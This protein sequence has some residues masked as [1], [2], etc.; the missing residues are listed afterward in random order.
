[1]PRKAA[2]KS[3]R[4]KKPA[5]REIISV[6]FWALA[7]SFVLRATVVQAYHV[8]SGSMEP[9]M[10][11]GDQFLVNRAQ[12]GLKV[13]FTGQTIIPLGKPHR[14]DVV[15]FK[16]PGGQ[17]SDFVKR[18][19]GLPG[20]TV[21]TKGTAV[22]INGKRLDDPWGRYAAGGRGGFGPVTVP[23]KSYFMMGDNRDNSYDSR[24]WN[25]GRGGFVAEKDI[26]GKAV[27]IL[28]SVDH[29]TF[30][31]RWDRFAKLVD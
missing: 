4:T 27:V 7:L 30:L 29:D 15:V 14:G 19:I 20:E 28:F 23:A 6:V 8:P 9:N 18:I 25:Q 12:Y 24:Y 11:I 1:M 10:V 2:K 17:G 5:Y 22:F 16:N 3:A 26:R 31:P 21:E 13:P